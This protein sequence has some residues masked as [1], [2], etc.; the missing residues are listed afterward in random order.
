MPK[1]NPFKWRH[2]EA[3][4]VLRCVR[5]YLSYPLSYR[6]VAEMVNE[7]GLDVHHVTVYRWVQEYGPVLCRFFAGIYSG[8]ATCDRWSNL[9]GGSE[10]RA[11]S[12]GIS[13]RVLSDRRMEPAPSQDASTCLV[14][15]QCPCASLL[16]GLC[17]KN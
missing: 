14:L 15:Q 10:T 6:Q 13:Y 17:C 3:N 9:R 11:R 2:Y 8:H 12:P 5:W 4:I 7:R 16:A 1:S